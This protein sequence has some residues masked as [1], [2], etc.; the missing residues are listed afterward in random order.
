MKM[1]YADKLKDPRWQKKRLEIFE[2]DNFQ[3]QDCGSQ[4]KVLHV[5]HGY[6]SPRKQPWETPDKLLV[7]VCEDC[8]S[9]RQAIETT[10]KERLADIICKLSIDDINTLSEDMLLFSTKYTESM[11]QEEVEESNAHFDANVELMMLSTRPFLMDRPRLFG[12]DELSDVVMCND[13]PPSKQLI[14]RFN[15]LIK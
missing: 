2:R 13:I 4:S 11:T 15:D 7:T 10:A 1:T 5:H 14:E 6:Y 3:C 9:K 12:N 8:H